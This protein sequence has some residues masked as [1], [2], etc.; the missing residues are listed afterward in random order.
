MFDTLVSDL[1]IELLEYLEG[2]IERCDIISNGMA[3]DDAFWPVLKKAGKQF[4]L[5]MRLT[6]SEDLTHMKLDYFEK[7]ILPQALKTSEVKMNLNFLP[8]HDGTGLL[9]FLKRIN[10]LKLPEYITITP[11]YL[12]ESKVSGEVEF[13]ISNYLEDMMIVAEHPDDYLKNVHVDSGKSFYLLVNDIQTSF[14]FCTST[15]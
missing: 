9:R 15:S 8:N 7:N 5:W 10:E 3:L 11:S 13:D 1:N 12:T 2:K 14:Y 6:L 4:E